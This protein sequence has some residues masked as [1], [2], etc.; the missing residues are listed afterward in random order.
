MSE[1]T[2]VLLMAFGGPESMDEVPDFLRSVMGRTPP[3]ALEAEVTERYRLLGGRSP[4]PE[5]TR[6]Q[7]EALAAEL[8]RR[9]GPRRVFV[10]MQHARPRLEEALRTIQEEGFRRIVALSLA[11]YRSEASTSAY[12]NTVRQTMDRLGLH[13][14]VRFPKDWYD[15]PL[16]VKALAHR[17]RRFLETIPA[18]ERVGIPVIFS[19]HSIPERMVAAGD[20]YVKQLQ[21]TVAGVTREV[22]GVDAYLGFQSKSG[23]ATDPWV[24][25]DVLEV[26]DRLKE[27]GAE[28]I[29]VDP[30]GFVA[31]HLETLYDND[32]VHRDHAREIGVPFFRCPCL[33]T[34][35]RFIEALAA[36]CR[37]AETA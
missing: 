15:H 36:I 16:Y 30:I 25:P 3:P 1:E 23:A 27:R 34:D 22:P 18:G 32:V 31:D 5:T 19:A 29:V 10:G 26:M 37:E 33:N 8:A 14:E 7:A 12:E 20:P 13:A 28:R 9:G 24:G 35:L 6:L 11:P 17:L 21:A 4:L 2:C